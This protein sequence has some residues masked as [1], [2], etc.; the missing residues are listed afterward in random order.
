MDEIERVKQS[1]T[2]WNVQSV[3]W[4]PRFG[5]PRPA[6][7]VPSLIFRGVCS[8]AVLKNDKYRRAATAAERQKKERR[9]KCNFA[10]KRSSRRMDGRAWSLLAEIAG[11]P[12]I[13]SRESKGESAWLVSRD[14]W[15]T[16]NM[17][18]G[19]CRPAPPSIDKWGRNKRCRNWSRGPIVEC[20][21]ITQS[22]KKGIMRDN[23]RSATMEEDNTPQKVAVLM[24]F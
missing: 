19:L 21:L 7:I 13:W 10:A 18:G 16:W 4:W 12:E 5:K 14:E 17:M 20:R 1:T 9:E 23:L 11:Y 8:P 22:R 6:H 2:N 24:V 3:G 15:I